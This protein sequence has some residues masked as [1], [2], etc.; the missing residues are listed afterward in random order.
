[1]DGGVI[2]NIVESLVSG[3]LGI[4]DFMQAVQDGIEAKEAS[5]TP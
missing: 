4:D 3:D 5:A 1:M 2:D